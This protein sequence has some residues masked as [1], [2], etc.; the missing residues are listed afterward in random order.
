MNNPAETFK[1]ISF[2]VLTVLV[3]LAIQGLIILPL[4]Y[5]V[6]CRKN[7]MVFVRDMSE[8]LLV[9]LATASR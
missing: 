6:I 4:F 3:G 1:S 2:Y 9:A 5:M 8:A 7:V